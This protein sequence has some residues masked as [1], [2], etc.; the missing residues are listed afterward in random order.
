MTSSYSIE[1]CHRCDSTL[2][3]ITAIENPAV[4]ARILAHLD[5]PTLAR[6]LSPATVSR[7]LRNA[8]IPYQHPISST[9]A[10]KFVY[11]PSP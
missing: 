2:N 10:H 6:P 4:I 11:T 7:A 8:L 5:L 1:L 9:P 3:I